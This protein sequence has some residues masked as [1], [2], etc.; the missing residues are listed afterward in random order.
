M[1]SAI[2]FSFAGV[3]M[4]FVPAQVLVTMGA[5]ED[6]ETELLRFAGILL[7]G[8]AL[9]VAQMRRK[10]IV[11]SRWSRV[12]LAGDIAFL[13]GVVYLASGNPLFLIVGFSALFA[14]NLRTMMPVLDHWSRDTRTRWERKARGW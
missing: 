2:T 5:S 9:L 12:V 14:I 11:D 8:Q 3:A 10:S 6:F 4:M 1:L 7:I 13:L